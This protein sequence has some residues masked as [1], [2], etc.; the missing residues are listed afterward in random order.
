MAKQLQETT[1]FHDVIDPA[2]ARSRTRELVDIFIQR[3]WTPSE[4]SELKTLVEYLEAVK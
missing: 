3:F 2:Q 4:R 1:P